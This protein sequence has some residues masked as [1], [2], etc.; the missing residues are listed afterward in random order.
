MTAHGLLTAVTA[1]RPSRGVT[2]DCD[3]TSRRRSRLV[4]GSGAQCAAA[5]VGCVSVVRRQGRWDRRCC[6]CGERGARPAVARPGAGGRA[7][8][9]GRPAG[10]YRLL[11]GA[12]LRGAGMG[13]PGMPLPAVTLFHS[14][15][16]FG[17]WQR[18]VERYRS[19]VGIRDVDRNV[20]C[21]SI[22]SGRT[23]PI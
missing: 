7:A 13:I 2:S 21:C 10:G 15:D 3:V 14:G 6:D 8:G 12:A 23:L 16:E 4:P 20:Q 1:A 19:A 5:A 11:G 9:D 22:W 18:V 17:K